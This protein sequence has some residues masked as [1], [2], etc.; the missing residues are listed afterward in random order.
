L[1]N[2][3]YFWIFFF[4]D[5]A[6]SCV[7][8]T[9]LGRVRFWR[10]SFSGCNFEDGF[11]ANCIWFGKHHFGLRMGGLHAGQK[12]SHFVCEAPYAF[13]SLSIFCKLLFSC[14]VPRANKKNRLKTF[15][16][17]QLI[18]HLRQLYRCVFFSHDI[19]KQYYFRHHFGGIKYEQN[20]EETF[21]NQQ[22]KII[23]CW[24]SNAKAVLLSASFCG[25][26]MNKQTKYG[27]NFL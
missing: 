22:K 11:F 7:Q 5:R 1:R 21:C 17:W 9:A 6:I 25:I 3:V 27:R 13:V 16:A 4:F 15:I 26:N 24:H 19:Q 14:M 23:S 2:K 12:N 8:Y 10:E 20:T 18:L